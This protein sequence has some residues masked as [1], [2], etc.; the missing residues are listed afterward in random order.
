MI[1]NKEY[2]EKISIFDYKG[3]I[4][5]GNI[6]KFILDWIELNVKSQLDRKIVF[7]LTAALLQNFSRLSEH[8]DS[9]NKFDYVLGKDSEKY[10]IYF[11][12]IVSNKNIGFIDDLELINKSSLVELKKLYK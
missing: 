12:K 6:D 11:S 5:V 9:F 4:H 7:L 8:K 10:Y 1:I 2:I 3:Q